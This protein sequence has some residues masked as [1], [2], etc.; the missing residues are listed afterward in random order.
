MRRPEPVAHL[1]QIWKSGRS[2]PYAA[3]LDD[4]CMIG[5]I[6][7]GPDTFP[8]GNGACP[9]ATIKS[10][11]FNVLQ[12]FTDSFTVLTLPDRRPPRNG[13]S[14]RRTTSP[15]TQLTYSAATSSG[16]LCSIG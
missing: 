9:Y 3:S 4:N 10:F 12:S 14:M 13:R 16:F 7:A 8:R 1:R 5:M 15:A 11:L 2:S 6:D